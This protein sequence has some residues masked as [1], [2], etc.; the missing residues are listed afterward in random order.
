MKPD[1]E[2]LERLPQ[3][4]R[5]AEGPVFSEPWQ[6]KAFALVLELHER[7][8]FSWTEWA[9]TLAA[10]IKTARHAGDPDLGNTYYEH[11]LRALEC[12]LIEKKMT[13][14]GKLEHTKSR[15][16]AAY[17]NTPHGQP[18]ELTAAHHDSCAITSAREA[19]AT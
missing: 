6:A 5:D 2:L 1:F 10:E 8:V 3:I 18:I 13:E 7:G 4:P 19:N 12:L 9:E 15:W 17:L 14:P 11:W 16:R